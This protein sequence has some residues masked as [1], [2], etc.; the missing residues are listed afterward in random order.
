MVSNA[1]QFRRINL[2][3][4]EVMATCIALTHLFTM[5]GAEL[6]K[7]LDGGTCNLAHTYIRQ[8]SCLWA[9]LH[10]IP[11]RQPQYIQPDSILY[12]VIKLARRPKLTV[13]SL[14][15]KGTCTLTWPVREL[16]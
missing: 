10:M 15:I 8:F 5:K 7:D 3:L 4:G 11:Q 1:C 14:G 2:Q 16:L 9:D 6:V 13:P 12:R